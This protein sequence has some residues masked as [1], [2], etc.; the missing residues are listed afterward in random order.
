MPRTCAHRICAAEIVGIYLRGLAGYKEDGAAWEGAG[1]QL[2]NEFNA[3]VPYGGPSPG[4]LKKYD[5]FVL[6]ALCRLV[7]YG[8]V[9][10]PNPGHAGSTDE[11]REDALAVLAA[12]RRLLAT[13]AGVDAL[14]G[15]TAVHLDLARELLR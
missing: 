4:C 13:R 2:V 8:R 7:R 14:V 3:N 15:T 1:R 12:M 9:W 6:P 10:A 5:K 11:E